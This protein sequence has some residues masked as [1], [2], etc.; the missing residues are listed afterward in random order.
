MRETL[1]EAR[2]RKGDQ[3]LDESTSSHS[4]C[5]PPDS[6]QNPE[7]QSLLSFLSSLI[8]S[9][10]R[11]ILLLVV[12]TVVCI[13]RQSLIAYFLGPTMSSFMKYLL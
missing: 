9:T 2:E 13:G 8:F 4:R 12:V 6:N 3:E 1:L 11:N 10:S 5:D 7:N